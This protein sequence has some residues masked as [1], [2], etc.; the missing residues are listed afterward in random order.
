MCSSFLTTML[1]V[2]S[3]C[4]G[5]ASGNVCVLHMPLVRSYV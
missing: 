5:V 2:G 1:S 3:V 4:C